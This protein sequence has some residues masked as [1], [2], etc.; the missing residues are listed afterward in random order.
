MKRACCIVNIVITGDSGFFV[1]IHLNLGLAVVPYVSKLL[2]Y[3]S[4][5]VLSYLG[6]A[7]LVFMHP[8]PPSGRVILFLPFPSVRRPSVRMPHFPFNNSSSI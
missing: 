3:V 4:L 7:F 8:P 2:L 5:L 1:E 6:V